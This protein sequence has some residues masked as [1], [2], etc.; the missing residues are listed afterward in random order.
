[1]TLLPDPASIFSEAE[2]DGSGWAALR[3]VLSTVW[4]PPVDPRQLCVVG[5]GWEQAFKETLFCM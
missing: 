1:M 3:S 5:D 4:V 2:T